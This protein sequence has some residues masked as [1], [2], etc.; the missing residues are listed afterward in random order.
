MRYYKI[1]GTVMALDGF[2][3]DYLKKRMSEYEISFADKTD[4]TVTF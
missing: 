3:F 2:D 1:A 4:I